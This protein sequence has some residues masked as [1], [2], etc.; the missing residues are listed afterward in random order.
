MDAKLKPRRV[1]RK[2]SVKPTKFARPEEVKLL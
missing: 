2:R 1:Y